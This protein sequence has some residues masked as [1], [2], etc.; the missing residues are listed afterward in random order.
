MGWDVD[1]INYIR[2]LSP[3]R[4]KKRMDRSHEYRD[5]T[6][7]GKGNGVHPACD[8]PEL[9]PGL[10]GRRCFVLRGW[11]LIVAGLHGA[12]GPAKEG[13]GAGCS[14]ERGQ[15]LNAARS[16]YRSLA[17]TDMG[18]PV[19]R[20]ILPSSAEDG[21]LDPYPTGETPVAQRS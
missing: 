1:T 10:I 8:G 13:R 4:M 5:T 17:L 18:I 9:C 21:S 2:I 20:R 7:W 12:P 14:V 19:S 11:S 3:S 16:N 6:T 15:I